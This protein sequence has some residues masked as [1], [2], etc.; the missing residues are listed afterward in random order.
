MGADVVLVLAVQPSVLVR[1]L[2]LYDLGLCAPAGSPAG[3]SADR[4]CHMAA[5]CKAVDRAPGCPDLV[6]R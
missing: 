4:P 5:E 1:S 3:S 2:F 6:L